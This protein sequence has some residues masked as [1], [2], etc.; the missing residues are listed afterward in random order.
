MQPRCWVRLFSASQISPTQLMVAAAD[1]MAAAGVSTAAASTAADLADFTAAVSTA[2]DFMPGGFTA[3]SRACTTALT[4]AAGGT[5]TMAGTADATA[6]GW[7]VP[8]WRGRIMT[9]R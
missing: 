5:G 8:D 3:A 1:S 4:V 6:G 2:V 7:A 9:I